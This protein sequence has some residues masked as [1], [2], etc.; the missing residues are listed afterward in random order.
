MY[1]AEIASALATVPTS[2]FVRPDVLINLGANELL[3]TLPTEAA[4]EA[5]YV[6]VIDAVV[7]KWS[8]ARVYI[9]RPWVRGKTSECNTVAG[10][11]ATIIAARPGVA[12]AG[13]DE[14][15]WLKGADDGATMTYDGVH[16][17]AAGHAEC[18]A[19]WLSVLW[20]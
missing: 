14:R 2:G 17:S 7:A 1:A 9:M 10:W 12:F 4:W 3:G 6:T 18:A 19:Q 5:D 11:I 8:D 20:P 13:P 16:Y 15:V